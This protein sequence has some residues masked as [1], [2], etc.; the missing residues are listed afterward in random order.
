MKKSYEINL[1]TSADYA[2]QVI[3]EQFGDMGKWTSVLTHSYMKSE[4][5]VGSHRVCINH[6]NSITEEITKYD[7]VSRIC[8]YKII[9]NK[10]IFIEDGTNQWQVIALGT[11]RSRL[12]AHINIQLVWWAKLLKP[13]LSFGLDLIFGRIMEEYKHWTE[14]GEVHPRKKISLSKIRSL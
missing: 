12:V 2:W 7:S 10:P 9:V 5:G 4:V 14:C 6:N 8:T 13:L 11:N 3:A 1:D